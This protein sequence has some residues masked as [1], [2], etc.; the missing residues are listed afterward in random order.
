VSWFPQLLLAVIALCAAWV[1]VQQMLIA[2]QKLNHDL[3]DRRFAVFTATQEYLVVCLNRDGGT[4]EDTGVFYAATMA[5]PFL[6]K[7]DVNDFLVQV[8]KHSIDIQVFGR[9]LNNPSL[10]DYQRFIDIHHKAQLWAAD[11]Y[12]DIVAKFQ[13]GMNLLNLRPFSISEIVPIPN[14]QILRDRIMAAFKVKDHGV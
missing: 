14:A 1:A 3:F 12:A 8:M 2:R 5:A 13:P 11:A 9:H 4:Q 6:F 10:P 7:K